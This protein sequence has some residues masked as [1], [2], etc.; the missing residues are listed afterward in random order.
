MQAPIELR[1]VDKSGAIPL[2]EGLR[3]VAWRDMTN[4]AIHF[5]LGVWSLVSC[6]DPS[7]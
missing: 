1:D 7:D 4:A 6:Q 5:K 3:H 2:K